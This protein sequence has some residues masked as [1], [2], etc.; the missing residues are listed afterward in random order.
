[1]NMYCNVC[2]KYWKSKNPKI[3]YILKKALGISIFY[4][5]S[6]HKYQKNIEKNKKKFLISLLI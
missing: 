3:S 4:S 5:K 6:G 1:M 2:N